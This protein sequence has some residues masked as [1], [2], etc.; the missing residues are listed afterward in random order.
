[1]H[2]HRVVLIPFVCKQ[3]LTGR[4]HGM[5]QA[6]ARGWCSSAEVELGPWIA[7]LVGILDRGRQVLRE[8]KYRHIFEGSPLDSYAHWHPL[9]CTLKLPRRR[10]SVEEE[11]RTPGPLKLCIRRAV[12]TTLVCVEQES[13]LY[14]AGVI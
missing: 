12:E 13:Q 2:V 3:C 1:M 11:Q 4:D 6:D 8:K 14:D 10:L 7:V 5:D 9:R